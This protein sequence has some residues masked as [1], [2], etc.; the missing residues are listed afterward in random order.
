MEHNGSLG[1]DEDVS[2]HDCD[3]GY[4]GIHLLKLANCGEFPGG[5]E[6]KTP[7]C[8]QCRW[9]HRLNRWWGAKTLR[10]SRPEKKQ[11]QTCQLCT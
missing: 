4:N 7:L 8:F 5:P 10:A 11:Q 6:F 1:R 2:Y 3:G 9:G